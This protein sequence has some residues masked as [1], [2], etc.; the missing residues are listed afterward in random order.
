MI[1]PS[2]FRIFV[3]SIHEV[4][5]SFFRHGL[6]KSLG[7]VM[8]KRL[9]HAIAIS[10]I[11]DSKTRNEIIRDAECGKEVSRVESTKLRE[12]TKLIN[13]LKDL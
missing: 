10:G 9:N 6:T 12:L 3:T 2:K 11:L 4:V 7:N 13:S 8:G 1:A 5:I